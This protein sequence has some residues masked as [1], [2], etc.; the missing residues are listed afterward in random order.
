MTP[1]R[2]TL[3]AMVGA[4]LLSA[5]A[6]QPATK[7]TPP[8]PATPASEATLPP[9]AAPAHP[10]APAPLPAGPLAGDTVTGLD[11]YEAFR[12]GLAEPQCDN[13]QERWR[14]H[15][16]HAPE[17]LGNPD[18]DTLALFGYVVGVLRENDLPTEF[19][20]IPFVESGYAPGARSKSGPAGL[21]QFVP[22]TARDHGVRIAGGYDGR[23]APAESTRAAVSYL[24]HLYRRFDGNWRLALMAYNAGEFRVKKALQRSSNDGAGGATPQSLPGLAPLTYAYVE[25]LHAL[26]CLLEEAGEQPQWRAQLERPVV[27]L[28]EQAVDGTRNLQA[29]AN[30]RG[31]DLATLRR[32]NPALSGSWPSG[33]A[34][35]ALV[36]GPGQP[37]HIEADPLAALGTGAATDADAAATYTVRRGDSAWTIA[38]RHGVAIARLLELNGLRADSVLKPGMVLR[39]R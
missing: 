5:C 15:F 23:L 16:A 26:A 25:K 6:V 27:M 30:T 9:P 4:C 22:A 10:E 24:D 31:H 33:H 37:G 14:R 12:D 8:A 13:A 7:P 28:R 32:L 29:W 21:W 17:R 39:L 20:L 3:A 11:I 18:R 35:L 38:K 19:A 2:L 34:P 1:R 36:P